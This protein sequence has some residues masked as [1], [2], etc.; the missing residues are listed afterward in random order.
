[1][2]RSARPATPKRLRG[3][4]RSYDASRRRAAAQETAA[5]IVAAATEL[6]TEGVRPEEM[7]YA[8]VAARAGVAT[9]TVYRHFPTTADLVVA[10]GAATLNRFTGGTLAE[11]RPG[12]AEQLGRFHAEMCAEP[13]LIRVLIDT[14]L[15][16]SIDYASYLKRV[17]ADVL[18]DLPARHRDAAAAAIEALVNPYAWEVMHTYWG[19]P[20]ERITRTSLAAVQAIV[21]R[22][23]REPELLDPAAPLPPLFRKEGRKDVRSRQR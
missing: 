8:D 23:R 13:K 12:V 5:H 6:V 11:D 20:R 10:I 3:R 14:P 18:E 19:L 7:S 21:D 2:K 9:R 17:F 15:R 4:K 16:S 22:F 1:M